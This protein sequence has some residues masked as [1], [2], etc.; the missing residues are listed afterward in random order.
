MRRSAA[1]GTEEPVDAAVLV[2]DETHVIN[3]GVGGVR[4]WNHARFVMKP[5]AVDAVGRFG[6][7]E[8]AFAVPALDARTE[9]DAAIPFDRS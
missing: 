6:N 4:L 8:E 3:V 7:G 2:A 9:R 1:F 5:E